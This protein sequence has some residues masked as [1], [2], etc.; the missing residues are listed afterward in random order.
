MKDIRRN[1]LPITA[2]IKDIL[3]TLNKGVQGVVFIVDH[4]GVMKGLFTDGDVRRALLNGA[5]FSDCIEKYIN[6]N[7]VYGRTT[8]SYEE[9]LA[10]LSEKIRHLPILDEKGRPH[11]F[12]SWIDLCW[13][14]VMKPSLYGNEMKYVLDCVRSNWISSR[15]KYVQRF[16]ESFYSFLSS[17]YALS[18]SSGT[19]AL[20][21]AMSA[22]GIG[23]GDEVI[24]PDL[25]FG[26]SANAVIHTGAKPVFVDVLEK[27]W[28]I[29]PSQ[30]EEKISEKTRAIMPVHLYGHPCDM[31]PIMEIA[32]RYNLYIIEDCAEALGA[33]YRNKL[34]GT[35]GDVGCFSFFANKIITTGE[36]GMVITDNEELYNRMCL[37]R[38]HGMSQDKR[39]WHLV[40]GFNYRMTNLQAAIGL[41]QLER[42]ED[43]LKHR[44]NI[45]RLY[46]EYL[47]EIDGISLPPEAPWATNIFW[48]YTILIDETIT[49]IN[50]DECAA[51]LEKYGIESRPIFYPLH[52]QP[53]YIEESGYYPITEKL[54][55][56]GLSLPTGNDIS[57]DD[58][59]RVCN[60]LKSIIN[61]KKLQLT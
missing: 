16:E 7:F 52:K 19:T 37:L 56:R 39:Y 23:P 61:Q 11:D 10:L 2:T 32:S 22:L 48:L 36:G 18:T 59:N 20:H 46:N 3:N 55:A 1:L 26:A 42:I 33:R 44:R 60:A 57:H 27:T 38:D 58:I 40:A 25:T 54:S 4:Q 30:I 28:T 43:I 29:S 9:N 49:E 51:E 8:A 15:G 14:P 24:V 6:R 5:K 45:V 13:L 41:A 31:N 50:R 53:P 21:L 47:Q 12:I 34:V 17:Q 35:F